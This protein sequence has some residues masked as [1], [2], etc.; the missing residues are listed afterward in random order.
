MGRDDF[1]KQTRDRLAMRVGVRCS[2]PYCRKLTTGPRTSSPHIVSIGVAAHITAASPGGPRYDLSLSPQ[3]RQ[4]DEN[5]IWL[6]QNCAKLVD[7]DQELYP[8][9]V[10]RGWKTSAEASALAELE[11]RAEPQPKDLSAEID[12]SYDKKKITGERHD[13]CLK[14]VLR[15]RG[16]EPISVYHVDLEIPALVVS[17]PDAQSS[18][19]RGRSTPDVA[20]FRVAAGRTEQAIYPGDSEVV[21]SIPYY[22]DN[23][24]YQ[25]NFWDVRFGRGDYVNLFKRPVKATLYRPGFSPFTLERYFGDLQIF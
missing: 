11:G 14:V 16:N 6:C 5:G 2:N 25:R 22:V 23:K 1:S 18:Y 20:F 15:N 8:R 19:V 7:N 4:S 3:Q 10:L 24:I 13:Y 9:E 21:I 17:N 12:I